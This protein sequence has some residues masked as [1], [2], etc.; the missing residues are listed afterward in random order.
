MIHNI[1]QPALEQF[2]AHELEHDPNVEVRRNVA[3]VSSQQVSWL[4][5][6]WSN[7]HD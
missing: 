6:T 4:G 2:I 3:Y 5:A 7:I 1:P